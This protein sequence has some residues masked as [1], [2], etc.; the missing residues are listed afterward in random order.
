MRPERRPQ[1]RPHRDLLPRPVICGAPLGAVPL[2]SL[3]DFGPVQKL[4]QQRQGLRVVVAVRQREQGDVIREEL[5]D[6]EKV[7]QVGGGLRVRK[8][9]RTRV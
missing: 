2:H 9:V 4:S 5:L 8:R 1:V 6:P 3:S 7:R